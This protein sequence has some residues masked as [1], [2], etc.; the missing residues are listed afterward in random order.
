MKRKNNY[1]IW[2]GLF[3]FL[4]LPTQFGCN[5]D[6]LQLQEEEQQTVIDEQ[7]IADIPSLPETG[8]D[9]EPIDPASIIYE[10][11]TQL[12]GGL[13]IEKVVLTNSL[14]GVP[15]DV[16]SWNTKIYH[17]IHPYSGQSGNIWYLHYINV[18]G[19]GWVHSGWRNANTTLPQTSYW[20]WDVSFHEGHSV[21]SYGYTYRDGVYTGKWGPTITI[22]DPDGPDSEWEIWVLGTIIDQAIGG[23]FSAICAPA[24][25][26][27]SMDFLFQ[28][29][30]ADDAVSITVIDQ[31]GNP[32]HATVGNPPYDTKINF[33]GSV[34]FN[35][36]ASSLD[37]SITVKCV[38][39]DGPGYY[40][41][42]L[43][44]REVEVIT[45]PYSNEDYWGYDTDRIPC[46]T[47]T[48]NTNSTTT[49][50]YPEPENTFTDPRDGQVYQ[51]VQI[52]TQTWMA[53][54]LNYNCSGS[55]YYNNDPANGEI[56][57]RLYTWD[58][59]MS[60]V[61]SGWHMPTDS[62]WSTFLDYLGGKSVAGG[63][64]KETG[65]TLW[66]SPNTGATNESGFTALPGG[67]KNRYGSFEYLRKYAFFWSRTAAGYGYSYGRI[68]Y[69]DDNDVTHD[70]ERD[71]SMY[72]VRCFKNN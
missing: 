46:I 28:Q 12:K 15:N 14:W 53:E 62:E 30:P 40:D 10:D 31:D 26:L 50:D 54:N 69:Y 67:R 11:D 20:S 25:T 23:I 57:G 56:Y 61:P 19:K 7:G 41:D 22:D 60:A 42:N 37:G 4:L 39:P 32:L 24:S 21:G 59:A 27:L 52:G 55:C 6:K 29:P 70:R 17:E 43:Y 63:K 68:L 13:S 45:T 8:P 66:N 72:S 64:M 9:G 71:N 48:F 51:T 34:E 1:L 47:V 33:M 49:V 16:D 65:T 36:Q 58:A 38:E 2:C 5:K 44:G 18:P 3:I 35:D